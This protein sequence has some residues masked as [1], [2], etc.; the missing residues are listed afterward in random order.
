[1]WRLDKGNG[2]ERNSP[3]ATGGAFEGLVPPNKAP[4]PLKMHH[5]TL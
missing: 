2:Q 1:L 5:E 3:V 4:R